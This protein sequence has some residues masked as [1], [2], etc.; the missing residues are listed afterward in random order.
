MR[1]WKIFFFSEERVGGRHSFS[2]TLLCSDMAMICHHEGSLSEEIIDIEN[3]GVE[4]SWALDDIVESNLDLAMSLDFFLCEVKSFFI[5]KLTW[6]RFSVA[7]SSDSTWMYVTLSVLGLLLWSQR[8]ILPNMR[9]YRGCRAERRGKKWI[10]LTMVK[11]YEIIHFF[12]LGCSPLELSFMSRAIKRVLTDIGGI[13]IEP[14]AS[15]SHLK[16]DKR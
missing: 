12:L 4:K 1:F 16:T 9:K 14:P 6:V 7:C 10:S 3:E 8:E 5:V 11:I 13:G 15:E 2:C